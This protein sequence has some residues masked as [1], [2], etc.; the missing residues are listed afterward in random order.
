MKEDWHD[1]DSRL[2]RHDTTTRHDHTTRPHANTTTRRHDT[3]RKGLVDDTMTRPRYDPSNHD[4]TTDDRADGRVSVDRGDRRGAITVSEY[5]LVSVQRRRGTQRRRGRGD[6]DTRTRRM[7][8]TSTGTST[9][10]KHEKI[11]IIH[12]WAW[13][14]HASDNLPSARH[15]ALSH[16]ARLRAIWSGLGP[17]GAVSRIALMWWTAIAR[18]GELLVVGQKVQ[19]QYKYSISMVTG[20]AVRYRRHATDPVSPQTGQVGSMQSR[21][22]LSVIYGSVRIVSRYYTCTVRVQ[23][24]ISRRR[25]RCPPRDGQI[26]P[27]SS[28]RKTH[29]LRGIH[30]R[31][32]DDDTSSYALHDGRLT[33]PPSTLDVRVG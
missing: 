12:H 28:T 21:H 23:Y 25:I 22:V 14:A 13:R 33:G 9:S 4:E 32:P 3:P 11:H 27:A 15:T 19:V 18:G 10:T 7:R 24:N 5:R 30:T 6:E 31:I 1:N 26:L 17:S 20:G 16:A 2:R 8:Y 29:G